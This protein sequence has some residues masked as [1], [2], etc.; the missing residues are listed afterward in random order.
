MS[1][2]I[3]DRGC[4]K[5]ELARSAQ[6]I[7]DPMASKTSAISPTSASGP[8]LTPAGAD[9]RRPRRRAARRSAGVRPRGVA[10]P[11]RC[12]GRSVAIPATRHQLTSVQSR[13]TIPARSNELARQRATS[14]E[15]CRPRCRPDLR[16]GP[17]VQRYCRPEQARPR[18]LP[19][20][21]HFASGEPPYPTGCIL[22]TP[23]SRRSP[24]SATGRRGA[25]FRPYSNPLL[26]SMSSPRKP[27]VDVVAE[28]VPF[29]R[30]DSE[31]SSLITASR[32][33]VCSMT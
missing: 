19:L 10:P 25:S 29:L 11:P 31:K 18:R 12:P 8:R 7:G 6:G 4:P 23:R 22:P 27:S 20:R 24:W 14:W 17:S 32:R 5:R 15:R 3:V 21:E 16:H 26:A 2:S 1:T 9:G 13:S 30:G 33:H 28:L